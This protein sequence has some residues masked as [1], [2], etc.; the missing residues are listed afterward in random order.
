MS[1]WDAQIAGGQGRD[2]MESVKRQAAQVAR[3]VGKGTA[4]LLLHYSGL[5]DVLSAVQRRAVGGRRVLILSYHRVVPDFAEEKRHSLYTLNIE[6]GTFRKHLEVLQETHDIVSLDEALS[7]LDGTRSANRDV[8]VIT[9]DDGY[10]DVYTHAFPIMRDMRIP[11][12]VYVPS[13]F[14]G[15]ERV[16]GHDRLHAA[17]KKMKDR[18]IGPMAVGVGTE[19]ER[20]LLDAFEGAADAIVALERLIALHPTPALLRLCDALEERLG[21]AHAPHPEGVL[22][23]TWEMLR[24]M[25]AHGIAT[26][27]HTAEHT[28]LTHQTLSDA[29]RE[30]AQ[31]KA[32]LEKGLKKPVRH[33]AY[34]NGYYSAGVAQ[35]LKAEGFQ[36]AVTTEDLPNVPGVDP[37]ALKRKVLWE[38]STAGVLGSYSA[39]LAACQFDDSFTMIA[40][41]KPVLG[42]RPTNFEATERPSPES[43]SAHG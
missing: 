7:V 18:R 8:A 26:G 22:P 37:L 25:D 1:F 24:E 12:I 30:I 20:W 16:L 41:Q 21:L 9:F 34:C 39:P 27:A 33:F 4:A 42:V 28:V 32:V 11:G 40:V 5:R 14:V 35:A 13:S 6:Q 36:S 23:M 43:I 38:G 10:R 31:C 2:C 15:T 3:R 29:R 19:A 17:L